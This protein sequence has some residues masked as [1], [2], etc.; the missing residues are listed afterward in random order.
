VEEESDRIIYSRQ[1]KRLQSQSCERH[2]NNDDN[3]EIEDA[4]FLKVVKCFIYKFLHLLRKRI[5][6]YD[7][8]LIDRQNFSL[9]VVSCHHDF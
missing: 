2:T 6:Y 3:L 8:S 7:R 9:I 5:I 4:L 1:T